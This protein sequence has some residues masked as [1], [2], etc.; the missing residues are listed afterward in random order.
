MASPDYKLDHHNMIFA[1]DSVVVKKLAW[2]LPNYCH[3]SS[4]RYYDGKGSKLLKK[5]SNRAS[6]GQEKES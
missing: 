5:I 6:V 2:K 1:F 3:L 4:E